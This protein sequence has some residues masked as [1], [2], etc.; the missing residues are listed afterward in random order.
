MQVSFETT[1]ITYVGSDNSSVRFIAD[2]LTGTATL[3]PT[4][5]NSSIKT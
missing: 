2:S 3:R 4:S 5:K 1:Q